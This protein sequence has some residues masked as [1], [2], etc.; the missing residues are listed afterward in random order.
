MVDNKGLFASNK[1]EFLPYSK[2]DEKQI[3]N[4]GFYKG[5]I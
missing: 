2:R 3:L 1:K 5:G 4:P